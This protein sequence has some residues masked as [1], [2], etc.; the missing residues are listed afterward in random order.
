VDVTGHIRSPS[1]QKLINESRGIGLKRMF[2]IDQLQLLPPSKWEDLENLVK[3][4]FRQ[5]WQD[6]HTQ[7]HGRRGQSQQGVDVFGRPAS[8]P[9]WAGVQ[10]KNKDLLILS[11]LTV[12]ELRREVK[13]AKAFQPPL[14]QFII[15]T[16]APRDGR[17]QQEARKITDRHRRRGGFSVHVYAWDGTHGR[18]PT[19]SSGKTSLYCENWPRRKIQCQ[20]REHGNDTQTGLRCN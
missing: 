20:E 1:A 17:L 6:F 13:K 19:R 11:Q 18:S 3:D 5:E 2:S 8:V 10:C 15:A 14:T 4:L 9:G 12:E 16:T 7:R